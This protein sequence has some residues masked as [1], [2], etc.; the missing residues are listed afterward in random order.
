MKTVDEA[1]LL[2]GVTEDQELAV[3]A[4]RGATAVSNW[5]RDGK[6]P[7]SIQLKL[8]QV[9]HD[10]QKHSL[11]AKTAVQNG[12]FDQAGNDISGR[13]VHIPLYD[14]FGGC[15]PGVTNQDDYVE[16]WLS[17]TTEYARATFG[18]SGAGLVSLRAT[19]NSM[20]PTINEGDM[21]VLNSSE[22]RLTYD[23]S[24]Y[25]LQIGDSTVIKRLEALPGGVIRITSD[26]PEAWRQDMGLKDMEVRQMR[27]IGRVVFI[28]RL[29]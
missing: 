10:L 15:G 12:S 6:M 19:G 24:I 4:G 25:V 7:A 9:A 27:I 11:P 14:A 22:N 29:T 23:R 28:G 21:V 26:N 8:E 16:S 18:S 3:L 2:L 20:I 5:R 1:K 13:M 17:F